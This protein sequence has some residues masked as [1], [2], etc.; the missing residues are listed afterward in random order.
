MQRALHYEHRAKESKG[1]PRTSDKPRNERHV[2]M[3]EYSSESSDDK[4]AHMCVAEWN[5]GSKSKSFVCSNSKS[6][7]K[8]HQEEMCYTFDVANC[9]RIFDYLLHGKKIKL[10]SNHIIPLPKQLKKHVLELNS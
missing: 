2:Y 5:W 4:E 8:S 6:A 10:P 7:S 9:D 1:F 3:V